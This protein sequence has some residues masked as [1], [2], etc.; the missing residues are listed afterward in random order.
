MLDSAA[1]PRGSATCD[2]RNFTHRCITAKSDCRFSDITRCITAMEEM[3]K[4]TLL[5][6]PSPRGGSCRYI[7]RFAS[8]PTK[9]VRQLQLT[10]ARQAECLS[11]IIKVLRM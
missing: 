9:A 8:L 4:F 6:A 7:S 10:G 3:R 5:H 1:E 11:P 2:Y